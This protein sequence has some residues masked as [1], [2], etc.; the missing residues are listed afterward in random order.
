MQKRVC[1]EVSASHWAGSRCGRHDDHSTRV[2][3]ATTAAAAAATAAVPSSPPPS[4]PPP[5]IPNRSPPRSRRSTG[6]HRSSSLSQSS[7]A[8]EQAVAAHAE[9][10]AKPLSSLLHSLKSAVNVVSSVEDKDEKKSTLTTRSNEPTQTNKLVEPARPRSASTS[11]LSQ[12]PVRRP[13]PVAPARKS[14]QTP[15]LEDETRQ[16]TPANE[17]EDDE[18]DYDETMSPRD[19]SQSK[20]FV[21]IEEVPPTDGFLKLNVGDCVLIADRPA[22]APELF[23]AVTR[24]GRKGWVP[25]KA[26]RVARKA[27]RDA[28]KHAL[29][30]RMKARE[31]RKN[32]LAAA[33]VADS[34]SAD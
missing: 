8:M 12:S 10:E 3:L 25:R 15:P 9:A 32:T 21:V 19:A 29:K 30:E 11:P 7:T 20:Y 23:R 31:D 28:L 26:L 16:K 17:S 34:T 13:L 2:R 14:S 33:A 1:V 6:K 22:A 24:K 4:S 27:E 5:K 18:G